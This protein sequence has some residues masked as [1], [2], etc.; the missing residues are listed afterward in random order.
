[1]SKESICYHNGYIRWIVVYDKKT[2]SDDNRMNHDYFGIV[3]VGIFVK[4][5]SYYIIG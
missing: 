5:V 2:Q 4:N 3:D 1:M